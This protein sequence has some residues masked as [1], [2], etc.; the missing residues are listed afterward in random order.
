MLPPQRIDKATYRNRFYFYYF[1]AWEEADFASD[2][3]QVR[4]NLNLSI[5]T[6]SIPRRHQSFQAHSKDTPPLRILLA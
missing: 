3:Y 6:S 2:P 5:I 1:A 4:S